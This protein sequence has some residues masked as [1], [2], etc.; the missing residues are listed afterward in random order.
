[1]SIK[2]KLYSA[3]AVSAILLALRFCLLPMLGTLVSALL[4][5]FVALGVAAAVLPAARRLAGLLHLRVTIV[6]LALTLGALLS[7]A[8]GGFFLLRALALELGE[9]FSYLS[10]DSSPLPGLAAEISEWLSGLGLDRWLGEDGSSALLAP[11]GALLSGLGGI[12]GGAIRRL[13]SLLFF[14]FT[15]SIAAVYLVL[16]LPRARELLPRSVCT[17]LVRAREAVLR[18]LLVYAR[19]YGVLF[20]VTALL[21]LVGLA[22]LSVPYPILF[23]L[24]LALVDLL[25]VL[26]V[27]TVLIP[28]AVFSFVR[29]RSAFGLCLVLLWLSVTV[30]RRILEDRL[31]GRGLGVHPLVVVLAV[32]LG[33]HFFGGIGLF[34]GPAVAAAAVAVFRQRRGPARSGK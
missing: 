27:G 20:C 5:F 33:R 25:P 15:S 19:A 18:G 31:V 1:M 29:G 23:A 30:V 7:L 6:S 2:E 4:P 12:V 14:L 16:W 8:V 34:L 26:G 13:P 32:C 21:S 11:L 10:G 24:L 28:W 3:A 22:L 17:A 9:L